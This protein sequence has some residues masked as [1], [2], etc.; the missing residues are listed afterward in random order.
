MLDAAFDA[1]A[2]QRI[3]FGRLSLGTIAF[4]V[5]RCSADTSRGKTRRRP[6]DHE[7]V[8][9]ATIFLAAIFDDAHAAP[10]SAVGRG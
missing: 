3:E 1:A 6:F 5:R 8:I 4:E 10:F 7:I 2:Q 9:A